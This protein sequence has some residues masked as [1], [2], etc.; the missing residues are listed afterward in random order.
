LSDAFQTLT[1]TRLAG[2]AEDA[3]ARRD[4]EVRGYAAGFA[5]GA[6]N[7]EQTLAERRTQLESA[8]EQ[9][10]AAERAAT[11]ER[12]TRLDRVAD[13]LEARLSAVCSAAEEELLAAAVELAEALLG[14]ELADDARSAQAIARRVLAA[15]GEAT[16]VRVRVHPAEVAAV[17][18]E[19]TGRPIDVVPD[20]SLGR[21]DAI[22]E[23]P[24]GFIDARV[25][26]AV[27]RVRRALGDGEA[28]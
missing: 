5:A 22:A 27:A 18:R 3:A 28:S 6:R 13:A 9:A 7:A 20:P 16:A 24:E 14:H 21:G 15:D 17:S 10:R 19:L 2:A 4:A 23:L 25:T 12:L 26:T 8:A 1:F 11:V